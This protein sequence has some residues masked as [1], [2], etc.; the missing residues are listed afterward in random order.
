MESA[1][2]I[3]LNFLEAHPGVWEMVEQCVFMVLGYRS[4]DKYIR[5]MPADDSH[6][7]SHLIFSKILIESL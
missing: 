2:C 1:T 3:L 5:F 7:I 4:G 6:E